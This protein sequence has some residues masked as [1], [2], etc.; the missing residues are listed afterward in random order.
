M[1]PFHPVAAGLLATA[2]TVGV[3]VVAPLSSR[4]PAPVAAAKV[5]PSAPFPVAHRFGGERYVE[6]TR[7]AQVDTAANRGVR[8]GETDVRFLADDTPVIMH[9]AT[10]ATPSGPQNVA[11][12]SYAQFTALRTSDDQPYPTLTEIMN[13]QSVLRAYMFVELK[14]TPT[15]AQWGTFVDAVTSR[16]GAGTP[17]PVI[18]SFD[19]A[20]LDQVPVVESGALAGYTRALVR[21]VGDFDP[22]TVTPHASIVIVHHDAITWTRAAKWTAALKVYAWA[23]PSADPPSE[24][25]RI[26]DLGMITGYVTSSPGAYRTWAAG[27]VC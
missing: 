15:A 9:D 11:D 19:P 17:K 27:R 3:T 8:F 26:A 23:D 24:W 20:V 18:S 6:N 1:K 25:E 22:T 10:V 7:N 16:A 4:P 5:C 13:D 14:V 21:S 2:I 12:L